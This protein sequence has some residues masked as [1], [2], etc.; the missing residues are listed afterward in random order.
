MLEID[1]TC[2]RRVIDMFDGSTAAYLDSAQC[3]AEYVLLYGKKKVEGSLVNLWKPIET[4]VP[5][6]R[7]VVDVW[8]H[9][10]GRPVSTGRRIADCRHS[11]EYW[12]CDGKYITGRY[13]YEDGDELLDPLLTDKGSVIVSHWMDVP[14]SP[15]SS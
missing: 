4:F 9:V 8:V 3:A 11:G 5:E 7:S 2:S 13:F 1:P 10:V 12:T 6:S 15:E 14:G